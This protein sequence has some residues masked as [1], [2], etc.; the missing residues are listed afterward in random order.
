MPNDCLV[1]KLPSASTDRTLRRIGE[2][3]M[4]ID[5]NVSNSEYG[6]AVPN[7]ATRGVARILGD[8]SV[9]F[10][11]STFTQ[12]YGQERQESGSNYIVN[13]TGGTLFI[14][15]K[16]VITN[17]SLTRGVILDLKEIKYCPLLKWLYGQSGTLEGDIG[18]LS[19]IANQFDRFDA[20]SQNNVYGDLSVF[21]NCT[22]LTNLTLERTNCEGSIL[23]LGKCTSLGT[24]YLFASTSVTGNPD[25]LAD[26]MYANG[27]VSGTMTFTSQERVVSTYTFT[28]SGW[29]KT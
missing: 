19:L 24:L 16:D 3:V 2:F 8:S 4:R 7:S 14:G 11:D 23:N 21:Q 22:T 25:D 5:P 6:I 26:A 29:S 27:R 20:R 28:P 17:L 13:G 9:Y 10:T 15:G 12:D 18:N 1:L